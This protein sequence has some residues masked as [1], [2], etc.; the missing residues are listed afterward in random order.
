M[1]YIEKEYEITKESIESLK[2]EKEEVETIEK[3]IRLLET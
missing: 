1:E 3:K 2:R